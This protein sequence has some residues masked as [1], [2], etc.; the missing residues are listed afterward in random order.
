MASCS[1]GSSAAAVCAR[2]ALF[3]QL[4]DPAAQ[5]AR[6][7]GLRDVAVAARVHRLLLVA[8]HGES[9]ERHH[10]DVLR[11]FIQLD[12][13]RHLQPVDSGQLDVGE[14][15]PRMIAAQQFQ[16][17]LCAGRGQHRVAL[18]HQQNPGEFEI[19]GCIVNDQDRLAGHVSPS[20]A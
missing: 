5:R 11:S 17:F 8:L 16:G 15:Q 19:Y 13:A 20:V 4:A 12:A 14:D 9:G 3:Q 1:G 10:C 7:D 6:V 2:G 18:I